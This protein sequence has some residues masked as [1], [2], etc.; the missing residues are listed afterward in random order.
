[1]NGTKQGINMKKLSNIVAAWALGTCSMVAFA[2]NNLLINGDFEGGLTAPQVPNN[3]GFYNSNPLGWSTS[4]FSRV[5]NTVYESCSEKFG[6]IN[7]GGG[8][9]PN[10][11]S[12][13]NPGASQVPQASS[14]TH[15]LAVGAGGSVEQLVAVT[16]GSL[17]ALS[18]DYQYFGDPRF[19]PTLA[20]NVIDPTTG[21]P[22]TTNLI[23]GSTTNGWTSVSGAF[24]ATTSQLK[25]SI[26]DTGVASTSRP[27]VDNVVLTAAVP[28]ASTWSMLSLGLLGLIGLIQQR[29][30]RAI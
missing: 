23:I 24:T 30:A 9:G 28:E 19:S 21:L 12:C 17:L 8:A 26:T 25:I 3:Y 1:M 13:P 18:Y 27:Y 14:G 10:P 5:G 20:I 7:I 29:K 2:G 16:P 6:A 4:G 11:T 22:L 15:F